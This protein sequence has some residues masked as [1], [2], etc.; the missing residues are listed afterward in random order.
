VPVNQTQLEELDSRLRGNDGAFTFIVFP[1]QA[2]IHDIK[3]KLIILAEF[4][5][6]PLQ[7]L[8]NQKNE[9]ISVNCINNTCL[10]T[11]KL[12]ITCLG[13]SLGCNFP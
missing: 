6:K 4:D 2:G 1:A 11:K 8:K 7:N 10:P 5:I 12:A 13:V 3:G 9:T